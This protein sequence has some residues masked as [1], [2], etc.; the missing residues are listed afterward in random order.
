MNNVANMP[1]WFKC[2]LSLEPVI[3]SYSAEA[4]KKGFKSAFVY[5]RTGEIPELSINEMIV[6]NFFKY[7]I[8][9]A[10]ADYRKAADKWKTDEGD[11]K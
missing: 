7:Q 1:T 6:F 10:I 5:M 9:E 8:D 4:I 3:D 2:P 11:N